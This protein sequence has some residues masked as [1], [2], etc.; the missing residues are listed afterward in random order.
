MSLSEEL[1]AER[2]SNMDLADFCQVES[3][4]TV[5]EVIAQMN[6]KRVPTCLITS[7]RR[8]AGIFTVR[9]VLRRVAPQRG[10]WD[11]PI[12]AVMTA[13][14]ITIGPDCSIAEAI[15]LMNEKNIRDLPVVRASGAIEGSLS[16]QTIIDY[17]AARYPTEILNVPPRPDYFPETEEGG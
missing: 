15:W 9:D 4:D 16:Y 13:L 14:P 12:D 11:G 8:L 1:R 7:Q 10:R 6:Q 3:G 17:L 5:R 2:V